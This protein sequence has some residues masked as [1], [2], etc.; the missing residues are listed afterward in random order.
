[1]Y[2]LSIPKAGSLIKFVW[3]KELWASSLLF[4]PK[5]SNQLPNQ[6]WDLAKPTK[7][8]PEINGDVPYLLRDSFGGPK[9]VVFSV[10]IQFDQ[11]DIQPKDPSTPQ[12]M[13]SFLR[14]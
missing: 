11:N 10:A 14:T 12:K 5:N 13:A 8:F 4:L 3:V 7:I 9:K 6:P 1:M 2:H